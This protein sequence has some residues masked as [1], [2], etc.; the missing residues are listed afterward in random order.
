LRKKLF[1]DTAERWWNQAS[2]SPRVKVELITPVRAEKARFWFFKWQDKAFSFTD[3]TSFVVMRELKIKK[4]LTADHH[5]IEAG[6][7]TLPAAE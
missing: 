2:E 1:V 7:E 6:F 4:A 5:F 3:C